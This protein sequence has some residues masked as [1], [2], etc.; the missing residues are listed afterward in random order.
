ML[1]S[2]VPVWL[3]VNADGKSKL[4]GKG[5]SI[6]MLRD[7][8][9]VHSWIANI[10]HYRVPVSSRNCVDIISSFRAAGRKYRIRKNDSVLSDIINVQFLD[11]N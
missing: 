7:V 2:H 10:L 4:Y 3:K 5:N 11:K 8:C 9:S 6:G 1:L